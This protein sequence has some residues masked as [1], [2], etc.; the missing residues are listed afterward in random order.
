MT[1]E[2]RQQDDSL[3]DQPN[4]RRE[5]GHATGTHRAGERADDRDERRAE[6]WR[7]SSHCTER[8]RSSPWPLG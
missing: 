2:R 4:G 3:H 1:G 8:E 6:P 7:D 5:H